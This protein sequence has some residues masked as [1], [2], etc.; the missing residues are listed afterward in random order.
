MASDT[1][2]FA[3]HYQHRTPPE[4]AGLL[5]DLAGHPDR[6]SRG[7]M[8]ALLNTS[9]EWLEGLNADMTLRKSC[10]C[11]EAWADE[12]GHEDNPYPPRHARK[13]ATS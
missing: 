11:G 4:L 2:P 12:P 7:D 9:A 6:Y 8:A 10:S 3:A 13:E 1:T 5:R